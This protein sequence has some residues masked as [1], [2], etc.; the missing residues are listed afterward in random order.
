MRIV[1]FIADPRVIDRILLQMKL[2]SLPR[3]SRETR[4]PSCVKAGVIIAHK[5]EHST[6]KAGGLRPPHDG[7]NGIKTIPN[8]E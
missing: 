7:G 8:I 2:A 3:R 4:L 6:R 5:N 1:S